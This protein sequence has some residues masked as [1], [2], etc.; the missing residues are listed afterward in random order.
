MSARMRGASSAAASQEA[1]R[2]EPRRQPLAGGGVQ[3]GRP[4]GGLGGVS[5]AGPEPGR[6]AG[7]DIARTGSAETDAPAAT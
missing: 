5:A 6:E 2:S 4:A 7:E 3:V 1:D